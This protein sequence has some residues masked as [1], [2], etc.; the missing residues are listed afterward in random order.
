MPAV[1]RLANSTDIHQQICNLCSKTF[2]NVGETKDKINNVGKN[3]DTSVNA[4][5]GVKL[6]TV[7]YYVCVSHKTNQPSAVSSFFILFY[8]VVLK[9]FFVGFLVLFEYLSL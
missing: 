6:T 3:N 8:S 5:V 1:I 4:T 2:N 9:L 7:T